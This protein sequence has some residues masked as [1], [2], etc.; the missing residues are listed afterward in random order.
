[1]ASICHRSFLIPVL[2]LVL[3]LAVTSVSLG[4]DK[5]QKP[6]DQRA[7]VPARFAPVY[8]FPN[9]SGQSSTSPTAPPDKMI[10]GGTGSRAN[11]EGVGQTSYDYQ[12]NC[13]MGRQ[14][15]H[16]VAYTNNAPYGTY[17]HMDWMDQQNAQLGNNRGIGYQ[18]YNIGD[19]SGYAFASGGTRIEGGF[20]GYVGMD[21]HNLDASNSWA[22]PV[23]HETQANTTSRGYWDY[24]A[25]GPVFGVFV[26]DGSSDIFGWYLNHGTGDH[27]PPNTNDW[28]KHD[29]DIDGADYVLHMVT[30]EFGGALGDPQTMSYYRRVG[31]YGVDEGVWSDQHVIDTVMNINV[32][33]TSSPI[34]DKVAIVWN[35]PVDYHRDQGNAIEF[36]NQYENDIWFAIATDNGADWASHP[37]NLGNPSIGH[38]VD[39][40]IGGGYNPLVGG[41]LTTYDSLD[42]IKAYC[43][44]S[45]LWS[46]QDD[47]DDYLQIVWG[48]RRWGTDDPSAITLYFRQSAIYHWN[49]KT[50]E[51]KPVIKAFWDTGCGTVLPAWGSDVAKMTISECDGKFYICFTQFGSEEN[52]C[53]TYDGEAGPQGKVL[54]GQLYMT[55]Y[56]PFYD[57][58]DRPQTVTGPA[59]APG[60]CTRPTGF[61]TADGTCNSEYW[62][63]MARYGRVDNCKLAVSGPAVDIIYVNDLTPGGAIQ[64]ESGVW[65]L[66]PVRWMVYPCREA[67]PEPGF[68]VTPTEFGVCYHQGVIAIGT[69]DDTTVTMTMENP[70]ILANDP[71][72]IAVNYVSGGSG[73]TVVTATPNSGI[74]IPPAG[75]QV[76]VDL[77]IV[78]TGEDDY[79]TVNYSIVITHQAG[80]TPPTTVTVPMCI[81][82]SE[83]FWPPENAVIATACK[84]LRVYNNGQMSNNAANAS[85]DF[86]DDPNDCATV[87]LYDAS[88]LM[89]RD[90]AG[91]KV[92]YHSV[93]NNYYGTENTMRQL[94]LLFVDSTSNTDYTY[95]T[96]EFLTGDSTIGMIVEYYAPRNDVTNCGYVIQK[97]K[98]WNRTEVTLTG[99]AAGEVL[100]W[101][102]SSHEHGSEN[103][104]GSDPTRNLVYQ[105]CSGDNQHDPCDTLQDCDRFAGIAAAKGVGTAQ[106]TLGFKNYLVLENDV[107][108]YTTTPPG[109]ADNPFSPDTT[110]AIMTGQNG[111][112]WKNY[113]NNPAD[114]GE[115]L[116]TVV[117]FGVYDMDP[118]DTLCVV[119][120]L[121]T[122]KEDPGASDLKANIDL[123]NAFI[124]N[125]DEIKCVAGGCC[126]MAGDAN[127]D[128]AVNIGDA[129]H[130]INYIFKSG[131][132]PPCLNEG[133]ANGDCAINIGDAVHLINYIFKSGPPPVCGCVP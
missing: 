42:I 16:R 80:A 98:F 49:Q 21:A 34:S 126:D 56:D 88:P 123:A 45:A 100:D 89:C 18:A 20:A 43:D 22:V 84:R 91:T 4:A 95:A 11:P 17:I 120:I 9:E 64:T 40:G 119:K 1:M 99:V 67:V 92:C 79:V 83:D 5:M 105:S 28:P 85:L 53:G 8:G 7:T 94:S 71:V 35:A 25:G 130:L 31:P 132:P 109:F 24:Y 133:D 23:A 107:F 47:P 131:P 127:D 90:D 116:N 102:V 54:A 122:S 125:H 19:C 96:A 57:G 124:A 117:T 60:E 72:S 69:T 129:V 103:F 38:S 3:L 81:L 44:L 36:A 63:S 77:H 10:L 14:I 50:D 41:N 61:S 87:Y 110:Y 58:W 6:T 15:E 62:S 111:Y 86:T 33:V 76:P 101:D 73:N 13:T 65:N 2:T 59:H 115:D 26:S 106:D 48:G 32:T 82:V 93:F 97:L 46:I 78:T 52:P 108:V 37:T 75:G 113:P 128:A 70:G 39:L 12:H 29:W 74:S 27:D 30:S 114:T 112:W 118:N 55:V 104:P 121:T 51:I 68:L 66:N